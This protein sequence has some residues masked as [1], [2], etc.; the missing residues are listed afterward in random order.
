LFIITRFNS[1]AVD[2]EYKIKQK[3]EKKPRFL[4]LFSSLFE[5]FS[6]SIFVHQR[7]NQKRTSDNCGGFANQI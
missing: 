7:R 6:C 3:E 2:F 4:E 5:L 1:L